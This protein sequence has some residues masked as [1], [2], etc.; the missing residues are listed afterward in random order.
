M[1]VVES[2]WDTKELLEV[3]YWYHAFRG[4]STLKL[5]GVLMTADVVDKML[6]TVGEYLLLDVLW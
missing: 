6:S 2:P 5:Y 4:Q 3:S 1:L